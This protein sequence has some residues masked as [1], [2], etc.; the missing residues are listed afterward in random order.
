MLGEGDKK[1]ENVEN[2]KGINTMEEKLEVK[3]KIEALEAREICVIEELYAKHFTQSVKKEG[4]ETNLTTLSNE[5]IKIS[6]FDNA[7]TPE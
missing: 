4:G 6:T 5:N 1:L 7:N 3:A 2:I